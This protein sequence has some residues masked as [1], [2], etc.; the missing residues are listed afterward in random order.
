MAIGL[1]DGFV[2]GFFNV[3]CFFNVNVNVIILLYLIIG[4]CFHSILGY[5]SFCVLFFIFIIFNLIIFGFFID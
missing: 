1:R 3:I 4:D 2:A 5:C